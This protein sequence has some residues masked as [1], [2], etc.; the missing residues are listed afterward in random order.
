MMPAPL[1]RRD[2]ITLL[3]GAAAAWPVAAG[4]QQPSLP[5]VGYLSGAGPAASQHLVDA[6]KKGLGQTAFVDGRNVAFEYRFADDN[7]GRLPALAAELVNRRAAV[8]FASGIPAARAAKAATT[9]IPIVFGFGEDPVKEG[10]VS[11]LNR[12]GG[13]IT[14]F[15]WLSNQ[16]T[17]ERQGAR[18]A[19]RSEEPD[20]RAGRESRPHRG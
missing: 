1:G 12:P 11:S 3:G 18:D 5:I 9:T 16:Y 10:I 4:A 8:I 6:V 15:S 19:R 13:N 2:F 7:Y 17:A 20:C 14:G